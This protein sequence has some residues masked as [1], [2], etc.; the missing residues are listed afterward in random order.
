MRT[1]TVVTGAR[2][3]YGI[4]RPVLRRIAAD[5]DLRLELMVT[6]MHLS[7]DFG[8]TVDQIEQDGYEIRDRIECL[9]ASDS[10][11]GIVQSTAVGLL[12][13][14]QA[15]ARRKP[16]LLVTLGDRFE[17][18][19][20]VTAA[21]PM[22]IPIAHLH[23]GESTEGAIDEAIRHAM[24]KMS[25]YHFASTEE[26][27][28]RI[29]QMGEDPE[30]VFLSGAPSLDNIADV[31]TLSV[32]DLNR[33]FGLR[34]A[35]PPLLVT[36]HPVTLEYERVAEQVDELI[37]ALEE[38]RMPVVFTFPNADTNG[39]IIIERIQEFVRHHEDASAAVSL[40]TEGYFS[41]MRHAA[42]MVG[43]SSS[44]IIEA[45]SF[46]LPVVDIG[47]RQRGRVHGRNVIHCDCGRDS[48]AE[49]IRKAVSPVF[50]DSLRG[51]Q[52]PY[53]DGTAAER[54]VQRL[55]T[56][57]LDESVLFKRFHRCGD[58]GPAAGDGSI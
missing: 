43:N 19:A 31:R 28:Q 42:A 49:S 50:R 21:L 10:P 26:Y 38:V 16:Q 37:A 12:G 32:E 55:K 30:R 1:I 18:F 4:Y 9:M 14:S 34:L 33:R 40:G 39:R 56:V 52:N 45:A 22:K 29:V 44:G 3:D 13:F 47:N 53:G 36:F 24:T 15:Y 46:E 27:R 2:S 35:A 7:A 17:M 20:A 25:H 51:M 11:Q 6:G 8:M 48:I 57:P 23:G 5:A 58:D 41:V 54:I